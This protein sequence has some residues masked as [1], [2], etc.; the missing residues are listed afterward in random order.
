MYLQMEVQLKVEGV[1][2]GG[3]KVLLSSEGKPTNIHCS[4]IYYLSKSNIILLILQLLAH[5]TLEPTLEEAR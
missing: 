5:K 1:L 4:S 3:S 2:Q